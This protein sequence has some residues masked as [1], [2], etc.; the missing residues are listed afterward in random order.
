MKRQGQ[1]TIKKQE[2]GE[3]MSQSAMP[4]SKEAGETKGRKT[5]VALVVVGV[6]LIAGLAVCDEL[7]GGMSSGSTSGGSAPS[8][9]RS[10]CPDGTARV[11]MPLGDSTGLW[12]SSDSDDGTKLANIPDGTI[13]RTWGVCENGYSNVTALGQEGWMNSGTLDA[14]ED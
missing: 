13:V 7:V 11:D 6:A 5:I 10:S 3:E 14:I 9:S 8:V 12:A 4:E 2:A 1:E